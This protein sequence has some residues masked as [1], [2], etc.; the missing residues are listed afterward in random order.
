MIKIEMKLIDIENQACICTRYLT[1]YNFIIC[2]KWNPL[3]EAKHDS[4]VQKIL[5]GILNGTHTI[6][7]LVDYTEKLSRHKMD[8]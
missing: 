7:D 4:D 3:N 6:Y 1:P 8:S 5:Y 2:A